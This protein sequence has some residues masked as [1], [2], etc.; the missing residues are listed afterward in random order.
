[1]TK[2]EDKD[3]ALNLMNLCIS[4]GSKVASAESCTGGLIGF[5]LTK[6]PG[7]SSFYDQGF[8]AYSNMSKQSLL[9]VSKKNLENFGAV[10]EQVAI[11]MASGALKYS[12]ADFSISITG[13]AG[14]G[15]NGIKAEGLVWFGAAC[16]KRTASI[17]YNFGPIGRDLVRRQSANFAISFLHN[18]IKETIDKNI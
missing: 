10:S 7:S 18:F 1:M 3:L 15:S 4:N 2:Y 8:I 9:G 16:K 13:I 6:F 17:H 5:E 12:N 14:P 11:D